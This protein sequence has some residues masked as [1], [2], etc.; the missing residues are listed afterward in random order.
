M[1]FSTAS[2][3][4]VGTGKSVAQQAADWLAALSDESCSTQEQRRFGQWLTRSNSHVHEFLRLS[5]LMRRLQHNGSWPDIDIDAIA[6]ELRQSNVIGLPAGVAA[7]A[8]FLRHPPRRSGTILR[9]AAVLL[10]GVMI[11]TLA[12][13]I[14]GWLGARHTYS[15]GLGELR[16][17]ALEDGSIVEL[18]TQSGV[19]SRFTTYERLVELTSGEAVFKVTKDPRRPFKVT[20]PLADV[21]AVGTQFD[22]KSQANQTVVTV[23]E[24]R[25]AVSSQS[26]PAGAA[27]A[28]TP[29]E[30]ASSGARSAL[31][32]KT[33]A[34]A[35]GSRD[36][37]LAAGE[38]VVVK[39]RQSISAIARIDP[40]RTT[41]WTLRRLYFEDTPLTAAA[42]EFARYS[43]EVI[44]INDKALGERRISGTFDSSDPGALVRFLERYGDTSV[45]RIQ[46]GW[47]LDREKRATK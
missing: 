33:P 38:Q 7:T 6:A 27:D 26:G 19:R 42:G 30:T 44:H 21:V 14:P 39:S 31:P 22:V 46:Q 32:V 41:G 18:N 15:T 36:V 25:V 28:T 20:T 43:P 40:V 13:G 5:A 16:S 47:V 29:N 10:L 4:P 17:V 12:G 24:G 3:P 8:D 45:T 1:K 37:L 35:E 11:A 9:A 34:G 2:T 23:I